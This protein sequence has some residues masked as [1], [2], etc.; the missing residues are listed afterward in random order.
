MPHVHLDFD[1]KETIRS[2]YESGK[3]I[4]EVN[5]MINKFLK[6]MIEH[7]GKKQTY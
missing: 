5:A 2:F 1:D 4:E 3:P 6:D 7:K